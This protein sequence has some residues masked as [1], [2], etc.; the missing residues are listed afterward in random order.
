MKTVDK[1]KGQLIRELEILR[2]KLFKLEANER[3]YQQIMQDSGGMVPEGNPPLEFLDGAVYV[4]FDRRYEFINHKFSEMFAVC[5]E[6]VCRDGFNPITLI[7]TE[8]RRLVSEK[9]R[10][11]IRGESNNQQFE[12]RGLTKDG[13]KIECQT[14]AFYI[15]YKWGVAMHGMVWTTATVHHNIGAYH[16]RGNEYETTQRGRQLS[17]TSDI[18]RKS[19]W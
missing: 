12:F 11:G 8:S 14:F 13:S 18:Y 16:G 4:I 1:S 10:K 6:E 5:P 15:P 19:I 17:G 2:K 3:A 7:A 9:Y